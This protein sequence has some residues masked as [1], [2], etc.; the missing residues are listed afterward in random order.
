MALIP[1]G[2]GDEFF[3][4][5]F[6]SDPLRALSNLGSTELAPGPRGMALDVVEAS[7]SAAR[8]AQGGWQRPRAGPRTI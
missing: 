8:G 7:F 6:G 3:S 2:F 4:P 5:F 1:R